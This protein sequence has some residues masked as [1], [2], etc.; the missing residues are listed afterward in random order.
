MVFVRRFEYHVAHPS[1]KEGTLEEWW[2]EDVPR[3][4]SRV[5]GYELV[6]GRWC[7]LG[8]A[9]HKGMFIDIYTLGHKG[10]IRGDKD[11]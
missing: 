4:K 6:K 7:E 8:L 11:H 2:I 5:D 3:K 1:G 10:P 9:L